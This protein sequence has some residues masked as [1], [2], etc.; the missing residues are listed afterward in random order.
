M[1]TP[2]CGPKPNC[3]AHSETMCHD[4]L[5]ESG[6]VVDDNIACAKTYAHQ[7]NLERDHT[8]SVMSYTIECKMILDL[9]TF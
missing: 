7:H 1:I 3:T 5:I 9:A 4:I 2:L 6:V 8:K